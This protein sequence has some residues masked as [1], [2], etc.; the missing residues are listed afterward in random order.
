[1]QKIKV[2]KLFY[3]FVP[4]ETVS[5]DNPPPIDDET[6]HFSMNLYDGKVTFTMKKHF[7]SL[8]K[9]KEIIDNYVKAWEIL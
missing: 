2:K 9:A 7:S 8:E 3:D 6:E 1:M 5:Y 4:K